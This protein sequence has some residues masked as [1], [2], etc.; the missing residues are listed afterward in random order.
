MKVLFSWIAYEHD[1]DKA[2][3]AKI[4][5]PTADFHASFF[6]G[7]ANANYKFDLHVLLSSSKKACARS[8]NLTA[9][10]AQQFPNHQIAVEYLAIDDIINVNEIQVKVRDMLSKYAEHEQYYFFSTGTSAMKLTWFLIY[11]QAQFKAHMLQ[12]WPRKTEKDKPRIEEFSMVK[13]EESFRTHLLLKPSNEPEIFITESYRKVYEQAAKYAANGKETILITGASGTGKEYLF[14]HIR[15]NSPRSKKFAVLNCSSFRDDLLESR[16]FGHEKG[17]FTG[18]VSSSQGIFRE[19]HHGLLFL[20]EIGSMSKFMQQSLLRVLESGEVLPIG[21]RGQK[22]DVQVVLASNKNL[23][24]AC[25]AGEFRW[26]L[27]HRISP[28]EL[29]LPNFAD[30]P[31]NERKQ[32]IDFFV[33]KTFKKNKPKLSKPA[34][35]ALL[36]YRF[37]GNLRELSGLVKKWYIETLNEIKPEHLPKH[38]FENAQNRLSLEAYKKQKVLEVWLKNGKNNTATAHELQIS[39]N[40]LKDNL[41]EHY[42][43]D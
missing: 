2:L 40:T 27:Y 30:L 3:N 42:H 36:A 5:G 26:D 15:K 24:Q 33:Q 14:E 6:N 23:H 1:F 43:S 28:L 4:G 38:L 16:L 39:V 25:A 20:D 37:P 11:Q 8:K 9:L 22:T 10:L 32:W 12:T 35:D 21:G 41:G 34:L 17:S 18:A 19:T 29:Q 7:E 31:A 13:S